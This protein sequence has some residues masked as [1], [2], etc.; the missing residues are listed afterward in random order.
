MKI[1]QAARRSS[2]PHTTPHSAVERALTAANRRNSRPTALNAREESMIV[3][4]LC[5]Y[6]NQGH[7]FNT[8]Y[9]TEAVQII[10]K[11]MPPAR[12]MQLPFRNATSGAHWVKLFKRRQKNKSNFLGQ[13]RKELCASRPAVV[14]FCGL[15]LLISKNPWKS[16][17][18]LPIASRIST[19]RVQRPVEILTAD[20]TRK[21]SCREIVVRTRSLQVSCTNTESH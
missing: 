17:I 15:T 16:S 12:S 11:A 14:I 19:K 9:V 8:K 13:H 18:L 3:G 2:I 6:A 21:V 4:L 10:F 20:R 5:D 7:H 1:R